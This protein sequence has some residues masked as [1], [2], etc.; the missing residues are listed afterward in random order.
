MGTITTAEFKL[1]PKFRK[2]LGLEEASPKSRKDIADAHEELLAKLRLDGS[3]TEEFQKSVMSEPPRLDK[4]YTLGGTNSVRHHVDKAENDP[5][6]EC[7]NSQEVKEAWAN[8]ASQ[9]GGD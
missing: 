6:G 5:H 9:V 7:G 3:E 2:C 1:D 8:L 4:V